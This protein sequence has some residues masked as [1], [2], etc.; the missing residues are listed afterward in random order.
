MCDNT[1]HISCISST[2][3]LVSQLYGDGFVLV[4]L[5]ALFVQF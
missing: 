1:T 2:V 5:M 4:E 3:Y